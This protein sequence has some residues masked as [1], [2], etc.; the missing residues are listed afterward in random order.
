MS[1]STSTPASPKS[2]ASSYPTPAS[3]LP[4]TP[5]LMENSKVQRQ[6]SGFYPD[7]SETLADCL[8]LKPPKVFHEKTS[9]RAVGSSSQ[10]CSHLS[11]S[12]QCSRQMWREKRLL[13]AI[14]SDRKTGK[15]RDESVCGCGV[16]FLGLT[17]TGRACLL[18][19]C[20]SW[21]V[22]GWFHKL[23]EQLF[24]FEK[25]SREYLICLIYLI[26]GFPTGQAWFSRLK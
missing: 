6:S 23:S 24:P 22:E 25:L 8:F 26:S 19:G 21:W 7:S 10:V 14:P 16:K 17:C 3:K 2:P 20:C 18:Q 12:P 4:P 11:A 15:G 5:I 13:L 9:G 1:G